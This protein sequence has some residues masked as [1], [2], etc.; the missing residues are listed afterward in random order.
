MT[1]DQLKKPQNQKRVETM[2]DELKPETQND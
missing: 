2:D 1:P